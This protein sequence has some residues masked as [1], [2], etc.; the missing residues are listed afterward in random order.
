[1]I[2]FNPSRAS[3]VRLPES[4]LLAFVLTLTA[5]SESEAEAPRSAAASG[6]AV[7]VVPVR[8]GEVER[9]W[10]AVGSLL[11][12]ESVIIRPEITGRITRV[13]FEEG[14]RVDKDT[15]LFQLDDSVNRAQIA[16]AQANVVLSTRNAKRSEEL[17]ARD[18]ISNS[19]RDAATA[20]LDAAT[21]ALRLAQAQADKTVIRAPFSGRVGLRNATVGDY[22]N[23]GQDL[24]VLED[25]DRIKLEFRLPELA[26]SDTKAGQS[27]QV[28]LDA[29]PGESFAAELYAIDSRVAGDTRSFA[30][31]ALLDNADGR[32]R[33]GLFARVR[34]VVERKA[35]AM[36]VPEQA[37]QV[38]GAQ[39]F[40]YAVEGGHAVEKEIRIGERR[41]G[42]M[43]VLSGLKGDEQIV[44]RGLQSLRNGVAVKLERTSP[45]M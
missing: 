39:S 42:D 40:L 11:A 24:V 41:D 3:T 7:E 2:H 43:E 28:E 29:Y 27:I 32:L 10:S 17:F 5:C 45:A 33:P 34:L 25:L 14:Q 20:S 36:I 38:R 37:V 18:L 6:V 12:N 23:P 13:G 16:Q 30:A 8:K 9:S 4:V 35:Q 44:V 26:L 19:D 1:M 22:V 31:R 21:A 15:V